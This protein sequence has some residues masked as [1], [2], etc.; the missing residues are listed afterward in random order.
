MSVRM[1]MCVAVYL[2]VYGRSKRR[3]RKLI[4]SPKLLFANL[5]Q[6]V[7]SRYLQSYVSVY[8]TR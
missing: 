4:L 1:C 3:F 7:Y 2:D 5:E 8:L 6:K